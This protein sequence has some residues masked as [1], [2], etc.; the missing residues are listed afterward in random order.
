[1]PEPP[2][3]WASNNRT[4]YTL[5]KLCSINVESSTSTAIHYSSKLD[6]LNVVA[7]YGPGM[8]FSYILL[9]MHLQNVVSASLKSKLLFV[10][11][12]R[13]ISDPLKSFFAMFLQSFRLSSMFGNSW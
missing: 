11:D 8:H 5:V 4:H 2:F 3:F 1:M 9:L 7:C 6:I 13:F 10:I 12:I